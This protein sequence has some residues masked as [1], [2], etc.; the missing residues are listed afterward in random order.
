MNLPV[1]K[2]VKNRVLDIIVSE[3]VFVKLRS[4]LKNANSNLFSANR[5]LNLSRINALNGEYEKSLSAFQTA[6]DLRNNAEYDV[7]CAGEIL[8]PYFIK[9]NATNSIKDGPVLVMKERKFKPD[10]K[11]M[12][13][14][15]SVYSDSNKRQIEQLKILLNLVDSAK[16]KQS[17]KTLRRVYHEMSDQNSKMEK[18]C[19]RFELLM[20]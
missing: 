17:L 13:N 12:A 11:Y 9:D 10:I 7:F 1:L 15:I 2:Y 4:H 19:K 14:V 6:T 16:W 5:Y 18:E 3:S 20:R 8:E